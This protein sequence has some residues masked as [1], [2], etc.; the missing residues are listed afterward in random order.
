MTKKIFS[1]NDWKCEYESCKQWDRPARQ[2]LTD[3]PYYPWMLPPKQPFSVTFKLG[4]K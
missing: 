2:N 4:F 1:S 3:T